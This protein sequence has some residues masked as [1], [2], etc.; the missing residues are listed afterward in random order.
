[1]NATN[2]RILGLFNRKRLLELQQ[3]NALDSVAGEFNEALA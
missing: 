2:C 3:A 1:M